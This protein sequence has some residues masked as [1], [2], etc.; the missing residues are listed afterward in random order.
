MVCSRRVA[1]SEEGKHDG[2]HV[3]YRMATT[4]QQLDFHFGSEDTHAQ[5]IR[6]HATNVLRLCN[7]G[8]SVRTFAPSETQA[9]AVSHQDANE[10]WRPLMGGTADGDGDGDGL[11]VAEVMRRLTT[12]RWAGRVLVHAARTASTQDMLRTTGAFFHSG[13]STHG[14][15]SIADVQTRGRGRR[16]TSWQSPAGSVALSVSLRMDARRM[17]TLIFVQYIAALAVVHAAVG[18]GGAGDGEVE[19]AGL[20]LFERDVRIK[21]PNDV[22]V[23][24][25][26]KV[27]GVLCEASVRDGTRCEVLVGV[28]VN[29]INSQPTAC[30][31]A[32]GRT[33]SHG[34]A[35]VHAREQFIAQF[36]HALEKLYDEFCT[37]GFERQLR[38]EYLRLWMHDGQEVRIGDKNGPKAVVKGLA[39]NGWVRVFRMDWQAF[40][41]LPPET[42]S[43][44]M[45][46]HVLK[47]KQPS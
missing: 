9:A 2:R 28:G 15:V 46:H 12:T 1:L 42:M 5:F 4:E 18:G 26:S 22:Y 29:V 16:G 41:D 43:L 19:A 3:P 40:Q 8:H 35:C 32:P 44:D 7:N 14:W 36:V 45:T 24:G 6:R 13:A 30:L 31:L 17:D 38:G 23:R 33:P 47:E 37:H 11:C 27:A 25:V 21:W 39:P 20:G 10:R 34:G